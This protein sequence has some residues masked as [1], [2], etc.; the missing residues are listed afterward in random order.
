VDGY[1]GLERSLKDERGLWFRMKEEEEKILCYSGLE[2]GHG[3]ATYWHG[4]CQVSGVL[5]VWVGH[6]ARACQP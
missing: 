4:P 1:G 2:V 5:W 6:L 3:R